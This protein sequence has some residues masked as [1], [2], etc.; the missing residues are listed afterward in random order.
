MTTYYCPTCDEHHEET[1]KADFKRP[2]LPDRCSAQ[3]RTPPNVGKWRVCHADFKLFGGPNVIGRANL[4]NPCWDRQIVKP[5]IA[6]GQAIQ[7][8]P[9]LMRTLLGLLGGKELKPLDQKTIAW[10]ARRG[11][12]FHFD[13]HCRSVSNLAGPR[14]KSTL[15][16]C[17][18][19]GRSMC[20]T[21]G[22]DPALLPPA[23]ALYSKE[24]AQP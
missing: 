13:E 14:T 17:L 18:A 22:V 2:I 15:G 20:R 7:K 3:Y 1:D 5:G 19:A 24:G 9:A 21:C 12:L 6:V 16:A 8:D 23:P 11:W 10:R 4:C